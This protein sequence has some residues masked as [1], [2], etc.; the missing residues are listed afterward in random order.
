[1][2]ARPAVR[3][4]HLQQPPDLAPATAALAPAADLSSRRERARRSR[5]ASACSARLARQ[6]HLVGQALLHDLGV[7]RVV[8]QLGVGPSATSRPSSSTTISSAS[9]LS[10]PRI[11]VLD[12]ATSSV[13]ASTEQAIK[14]AL[15]EVMAGRTTFVI[16]HRLSTIALAD[17]IVVLEDGRIAARG[18]HDELLERSALYAE[19]AAKGLPDQVFLNRKP[20]EG[21]VEAAVSTAVPTRRDDLVRRW[22]ATSGRGRKLRG[23]LALLRPYRGRTMLMFASLVIGTAA[24]LAP[25]PLA[26]LAI[27]DGIVPRRSRDAEPRRRRVPRL[28]ADPLGGDVGAD[29]AR[30]L[31]RPARPAGP[32]DPA[33]RAPAG[34]LDRL[35]LAPPGRR[36]HLAADER[37]AGARPARLRRRRDAV[38]RVADAVRHR[39]DPGRARLAAR[40][41]D[42]PDLP[43]CSGSG[44][45][46]SGSSAPTPTAPRARR[47]PRSP[48]TCRRRCR[49]S[50]SCASFG[51]ER[52]HEARLLRP[53]R[54]EPRGEHEDGQPQRRLL[55]GG[56]AAVRARDR[57]RSCSTAACRRSRAT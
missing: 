31:G 13:D 12:D 50:A 42:V 10:D 56:R 28:G 7:Q 18:T 29:L 14:D 51:Q 44:R 32:P 40:A 25:P 26:K 38:R 3:P 37:R 36:D 47:S 53:Q 41:A 27:D 23:L 6:E 33:L 15:R 5:P 1:M 4:Q 22:R 39:G 9:A 30:R 8:E 54:R 45:S 11:L 57:G 35:L 49:A 48:R 55:P 21:A 24:S 34:A 19:I 43:A 52:R 20:S 2:L 46:R 17:D 16:A